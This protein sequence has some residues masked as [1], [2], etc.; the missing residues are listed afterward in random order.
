M[1]SIYAGVL[2]SLGG[3]VYL[4]CD[5]R[6]VGATLFSVAL[7]CICYRGD[8][9]YTGKVCYI[10]VERSGKYVVDVLDA[11]LGNLITTIIFGQFV[12]RANPSLHDV[13]Q[14]VCA[15]KMQQSF[16]QT[17]FRS[18]FCGV[19]IYLAVD[20][21]KKHKTTLAIL[22]CVPVFILSG[23]EHSIA[24]SFYISC[25]DAYSFG[26]GIFLLIVIVGNAVGGMLIPALQEIDLRMEEKNGKY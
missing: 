14:A 1:K 18:F 13:A 21:F 12:A 20:I 23:W 3:T 4:A 10:P 19:L 17:F 5:N 16:V 22:F 2:I 24:D 6:Y 7:L 26:S 25:A 15:A 8:A 9:L 11:L